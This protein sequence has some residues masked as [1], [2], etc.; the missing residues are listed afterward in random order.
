[1]AKK[2]FAWEC[3][4]GKIEYGL[5]PPAECVECQGIDSYTKIPDDELEERE[6][7]EVLSMRPEEEDAE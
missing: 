6:A 2:G 4:C 1:M 3:E 5:Y 7:E